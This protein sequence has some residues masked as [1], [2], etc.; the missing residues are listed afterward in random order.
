MTDSRKPK[1]ALAAKPKLTP[2]F[3]RNVKPVRA[4]L[5]ETEEPGGDRWFN[6]YDGEDWLFGNTDPRIPVHREVLPKRL[7]SKWRGLASNP[8]V[9]Q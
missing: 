7:L 3:S 1:L 8:K 9:K 6:L 5:Y 4:G 2:W